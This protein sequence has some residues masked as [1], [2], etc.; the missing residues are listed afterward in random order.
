MTMTLPHPPLPQMNESDSS[1]K[2]KPVLVDLNESGDEIRLEPE[3]EFSFGAKI[4]E[5]FKFEHGFNEL[6]LPSGSRDVEDEEEGADI[7]ADPRV[8]RDVANNEVEE[9]AEEAEE[10]EDV[11]I[12]EVSKSSFVPEI[13][14]TLPIDGI[15]LLVDDLPG[16][17]LGL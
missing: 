6:R 9:E 2:S 7:E 5:D 15:T 3:F 14:T 13:A 16:S 17:E 4:S 10:L 11:G 12:E 8:S 1:W